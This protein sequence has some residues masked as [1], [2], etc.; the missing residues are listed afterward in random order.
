MFEDLVRYVLGMHCTLGKTC[1]TCSSGLPKQLFVNIHKAACFHRHISKPMQTSLP[2]L[3]ASP[4]QS[5]R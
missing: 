4:G 2:I 1:P 3:A 5:A